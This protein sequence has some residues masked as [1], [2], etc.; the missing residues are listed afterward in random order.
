LTTP[1]SRSNWHKEAICRGQETNLWFPETP[2]GRDYFAKARKVCAECP[3]AE[4]CLEFALGF[5]DDFDRFG[6]FGG[7]SPKERA[8]IRDERRRVVRIGYVSEVKYALRQPHAYTYAMIAKYTPD[9]AEIALRRTKT[10]M[11][12]TQIPPETRLVMNSTHAAP[13]S[14]L[15]AQAAAALIMAG[16][17]DPL[18]ARTCAALFMGASYVMELA[19]QGGENGSLTPQESAAAQGVAELA[20]R[21]WRHHAEN[22]KENS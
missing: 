20:M 16:W 2:Q 10:D 12:K 3:V 18:D 11:E 7:K 13:A 5:E 1:K 21:V 15:T 19:R 4:D 14:T 22:A 17:E 8:K 6:M 9:T